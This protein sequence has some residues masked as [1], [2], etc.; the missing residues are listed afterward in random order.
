MSP[1][2]QQVLD[3]AISTLIPALATLLAGWFAILGQRIKAKY[4]EKVNTEVKKSVVN[5]TV[6]YIQ[7]VYKSLDGASKLQHAIEQASLV[8][9]QKGIS[10]SEVELKM[11]IESA[12]Y[13]MNK[14]FYETEKLAEGVSEALYTSSDVSACGVPETDNVEKEG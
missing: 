3:T 6:Q 5:D 11:L 14:G 7:Q 9:N 8:L 4:D 2:M 1:E 12:V 13:G 10:V